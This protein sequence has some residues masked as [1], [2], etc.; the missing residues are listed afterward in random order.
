MS[1]RPGRS[2]P[3]RRWLLLSHVLFAVTLSVPTIVVVVTGTPGTR[4]ATVA[5]ALAFAA[6]YTVF[7]V[8]RP[9]W[10]ERS[11]LMVIYGFGALTFYTVLNVREGAYILLLYSLL[12]QFFSRLPRVLAVLA[13]TAM[14]VLP[15]A[16]AGNAGDLLDDRGALL[17]LLATLGLGLAVTALVE[18]FGQQVDAQK[19]TIAELESARS[20]IG[21]LLGAAQR[22]L[23]ERDALAR[24]GHALIAARTS[25]EVAAAL[26]EQLADHSAGVRGVALLATADVHG[27]CGVSVDADAAYGVAVEAVAGTACPPAGATVRLPDRP[28]GDQ[29]AVVPVAELG[30][31]ADRYADAGVRSIALLPMVVAD[32]VDTAGAHEVADLLWLSLRT[33][34]YNA[35]MRRDLSTIATETALALANLRLAAQAAQQ[36]RAAGV[37]AERQR[38]AHEI[39]DTLAQ[40]FTSIV[41]QLEAADQALDADP[42]SAAAH[43]DRARRTARESLGEARRT[44]EALRPRPL[45]QA[46]LA[47]ALR[48]VA[49]RWRAAQQRSTAINV[50]VD[51]APTSGAPAIDAA[52]LRV[53][54][55]ALT[56]VGR[57]A[58]ARTVN[59]TL[60]YLDDLI[61]LDIQD[62]G[63]GF[64][65]ADGTRHGDVSAG[66]YGLLV[67]R[68]RMAAIGGD[69]VVES[70]PGEGTTVAARAQLRPP[71][72]GS[73]GDKLRQVATGEQ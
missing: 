35:G 2:D 63:S 66:G 26:A 16:V 34:E 44:V 57:H 43:L 62:D 5:V 15:T 14:A 31:D 4:A 54:Q 32:D 28:A 40:G 37:A 10:G 52:L 72:T 71:A 21:D 60:S 8:A 41:T 68:E 67:M 51:G 7:F 36:G 17:N 65:A 24:T 30:A 56:N 48:A 70:T 38:L 42:A 49:M 1:A 25:A 46:S 64:D 22:D 3:D 12:P 58:D 59:L 13:T 18:A 11:S 23:Q 27:T 9:G 45:E 33:A 69:L 73:T 6:W 55:E 53:A 39:H 19:G 47:E 50:V 29:I 20:E 61:L